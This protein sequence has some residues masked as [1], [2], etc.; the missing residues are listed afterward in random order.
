LDFANLSGGTAPS[1]LATSVPGDWLNVSYQFPDEGFSL[2]DSINRLVQLALNQSGGNVSHAARMLG[3][4]RDFVR[5]RLHGDRR[6]PTVHLTD[7][8]G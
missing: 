3:V 8:Q 5:Y 1:D 4:T 2:E 7:E 6:E